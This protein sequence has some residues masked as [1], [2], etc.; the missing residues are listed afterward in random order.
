MDSTATIAT[1]RYNRKKAEA[2]RLGIGVRTLERWIASRAIP[3]HQ[4]G[5]IV[6]FDPIEVDH[7]LATRGRVSAVGVFQTRRPNKLA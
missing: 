6:L 4:V 3:F 2:E 5:R 1:R 7:T